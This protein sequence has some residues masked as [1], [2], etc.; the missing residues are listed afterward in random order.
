MSQVGYLKALGISH[1]VYSETMER[2][3]GEV[4]KTTEPPGIAKEVKSK[5]KKDQ[6]FILSSGGATERRAE[7]VTEQMRF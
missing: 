2:P 3:E 7:S 4:A 1:H 6:T 5:L